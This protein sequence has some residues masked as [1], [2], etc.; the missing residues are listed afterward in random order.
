[1]SDNSNDRSKPTER[2]LRFRQILILAA[3][4]FG[5]A[6]AIRIAGGEPL[7]RDLQDF[8]ARYFLG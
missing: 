5:F 4:V 3:L 6:F 2:P 8:I 7:P 1:M